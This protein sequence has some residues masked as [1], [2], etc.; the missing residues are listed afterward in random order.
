MDLGV[1][2]ENIKVNPDCEPDAPRATIV[3]RE[4]E[5]G[6]KM[7]GSFIG[8]DSFVLNALKIK[9]ETDRLDELV[10]GSHR[11]VNTYSSNP[12]TSIGGV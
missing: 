9:G 4:R 12:S 3:R 2:I 8:T 7:L 1:P 5:Y 10:W 6:F 11:V